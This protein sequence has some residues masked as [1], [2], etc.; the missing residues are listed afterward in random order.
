MFEAYFFLIGLCFGSFANVVIYRLPQGKSVVRPGSACPQCSHSLRWTELIPVLSWIFQKGKCTQCSSRISFRYPVV[1]LLTG[2]G[3]FLVFQKF[4]LSFSTFEYC[5]FVFSL[6]VVS[7][8]DLDH[9]ILPDIFTLSGLVIGFAGSFLSTQRFWWESLLGILLGG[10]VLWS[11]AILYYW[12]RKEEGMGGGD[13]KLLAWIGAVL[14][15]KSLPFVILV[16]SLLGTLVGVAILL[17]SRKSLKTAIPFGPY[18]AFGAVSYLFGG[19]TLGE[20][21]LRLFF[22]SLV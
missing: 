17:S 21:Y 2:L 6:I 15:W 5:L 16:A 4:G 11:I 20:L 9:M 12:M 3:F 8:I 19:E 13:I 18:L 7:F 1:E 10:G 14:G 22:P